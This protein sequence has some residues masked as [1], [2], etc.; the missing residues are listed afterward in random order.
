MTH[1][2]SHKTSPL[3]D[4][5]LKA[6][7]EPGNLRSTLQRTA[8]IACKFFR[9]D[10]C[11]LFPFNPLTGRSLTAILVS[12]S[13]PDENRAFYIRQELERLIQYTLQEDIFLL[14]DIQAEP[15]Y[16]STL[17]DTDC[18]CDYWMAVV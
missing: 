13:S 7:G 4:V 3:L 2:A 10:Y 9:A 16:Q 14:A 17:A 15:E 12:D 18:K 8:Q 5:V 11:T 1:H 6:I